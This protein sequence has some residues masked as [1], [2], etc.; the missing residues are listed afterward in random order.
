[1]RLR[2]RFGIHDWGKYSREWF[3]I[4]NYKSWDQWN[5]QLYFVY[6]SLECKCCGIQKRKLL[7]KVSSPGSHMETHPVWD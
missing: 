3:I 1:M 4:H 7:E 5:Y 2:C 6:R